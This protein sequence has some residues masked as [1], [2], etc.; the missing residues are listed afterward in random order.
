ME[1]VNVFRRDSS[2]EK[3]WPRVSN[4][5]VEQSYKENLKQ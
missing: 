1:G 4:L 5:V 2:K 3:D